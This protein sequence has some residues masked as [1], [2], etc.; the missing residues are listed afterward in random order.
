MIRTDAEY[1]QTVARLEQERDLLDRQ[2]SKLVE[3]GFAGEQLE[4]AMAPTLSFHQQLKEELEAYERL[5][6]GDFE[7]IYNLTS[8]GGLLIG[9]RISSGI[10]QRELADRLGVSESIVSR[11]EK[12][13]YYG[14]SVERAQKILTALQARIR[15]E[16]TEP[17]PIGVPASVA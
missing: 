14:I 17:I 9:L 2:R 16:L 10:S 5:K 13:E 1:R 15:L 3:M 6:R 11:D 7:P 8:I 12:N 4:R